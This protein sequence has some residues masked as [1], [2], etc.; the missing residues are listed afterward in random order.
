MAKLCSV[1]DFK[2]ETGVHITTV[3]TGKMKGMMSLS[4]SCLENPYCKAY[5]QKED[6]ICSHCYSIAQMDRYK[7]M[8]GC[9]ENNTKILTSKILK[10]FPMLNCVFFRFESFGDIQNVTQVINYFNICKANK[11]VRFALWTKNPN[12]ISQA[13]EQ[14][15][16]KPK[17]L[18]ILLSS[19]YMNKPTDVSKWDF[20]DKVFTVY[21]K[22]TIKKENVDINC[23]ARNCLM[24]HKCYTKNKTKNINEELK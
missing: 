24:C 9:F 11:Y 10:V 23:G 21:D 16:A 15:N 6:M 14:G 13:I 7:N 5:S 3:H 1:S 4:T 18:Q 2:K 22:P 19:H 17:N 8:Q 12:I 20:I